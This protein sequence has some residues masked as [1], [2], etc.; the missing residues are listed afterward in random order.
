[1]KT[2]ASDP[3]TR[4]RDPAENVLATAA[5]AY[6]SLIELGESDHGDSPRPYVVP[7]NFVHRPDP[8]DG[9]GS[10]IILFHTGPGRK[11]AALANHPWVCIAVTGE[12][13]FVRGADPCSDGFSYAS[14]L[15][16]GQA[17]VLESPEERES[18]LRAIVAKYDP[19]AADR[20]FDEDVLSQTL[21]YRVSI[22]ESSYKERPRS[23]T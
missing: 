9:P 19:A 16:W 18:A 14:V 11:T 17:E 6:L 1:M 8:G 4:D 5:T 7:L 21:V 20:P 15:V 13:T 23:V 12:A 10:G 2:A 22:E 3:K